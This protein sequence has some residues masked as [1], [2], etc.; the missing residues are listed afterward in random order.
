MCKGP[1]AGRNI[2]PV[3]AW[4][5][6]MWPGQ[7]ERGEGRLESGGSQPIEGSQDLTGVMA[8]ISSRLRKSQQEEDWLAGDWRQVLP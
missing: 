6:L 4:R 3:I 2:K 5:R 7:R 1:V 8:F